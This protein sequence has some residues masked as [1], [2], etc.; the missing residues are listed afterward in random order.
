MKGLS[1]P[2]H[3]LTRPKKAGFTLL[4]MIVILTLLGLITAAIAYSI[5]AARRKARDNQRLTELS[6]MVKAL[7]IY[8]QENGAYPPPLPSRKYNGPHCAR[9]NQ[10]NWQTF[11]GEQLKRYIS[12]IPTDP[13]NTPDCDWPMNDTDCFIYVYCYVSDPT[14]T[15]NEYGA[16]SHS[17][18]LFA[19]LETPNH[20]FSCQNKHYRYF[21]NDSL[22]LCP[23]PMTAASRQAYNASSN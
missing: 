7:E 14:V 11:L 9:S 5:G 4:E 20:E 15:P 6:Q 1:V 2:P 13:I 8:R 18:D 10:D 3:P 19:R 21:Y 16:T 22:E 17:Y 12:K 23:E